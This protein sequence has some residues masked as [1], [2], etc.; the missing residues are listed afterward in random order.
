MCG[1][2]SD[3]D[4]LLIPQ[5]DPRPSHCPG[6]M[7]DEGKAYPRSCQ[8]CGIYKCR[9]E[10]PSP[11]LVPASPTERLIIGF[12]GLAGSGKSTAALHT[13]YT[14]VRFAG[15]LKDMMRALGLT[16]QEIE[17]DRKEKPCNLLVKENLEEIINRIPDAFRALGVPDEE[18]NSTGGGPVD[19]LCGRS[20]SF[21][22]AAL[23]GVIVQAIVWGEKNGGATPRRFMQMTGTEWGRDLI[24]DTLW[25]D[26]WLRNVART[27]G[28][29]VCDDVRFPN[30]AD[31][32]RTAGGFL[33]RVIRPGAGG[34]AAGH[35][36]EG[37]DLG[38]PDDTIPNDCS[39]EEFFARVDRVVR[40]LSWSRAGTA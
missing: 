1:D 38:A 31:A 21:A 36:S 28:P 3:K 37:Q 4:D 7:R 39:I 20:L 6:R 2:C 35:S 22:A 5:M 10:I 17:G 8:T 25:T 14:R 24:C 18:I 12:T 23:V 32:I 27:T 33:V 16:E 11:P 19:I 15:P 13:G 40:D 34:G 9:F 29:V 26:L 30:E